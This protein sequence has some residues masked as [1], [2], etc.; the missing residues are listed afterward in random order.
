MCLVVLAA[1]Y[2]PECRTHLASIPRGTTARCLDGLSV[3]HEPPTDINNDLAKIKNGDTV[4][5]AAAGAFTSSS[6]GVGP[7][8]VQAGEKDRPPIN[9]A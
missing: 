7:I 8:R 6:Q 2:P 3:T 5:A 4:A 9:A 1:V